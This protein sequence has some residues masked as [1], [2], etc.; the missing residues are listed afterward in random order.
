LG[1][2]AFFLKKKESIKPLIQSKV[3]LLAFRPLFFTRF[4][5]ESMVT[6]RKRS[7]LLERTLSMEGSKTP[8][9]TT[10]SHSLA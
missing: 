1:T 10:S 3:G 6:Q 8:L 5:L 7:V 4:T 2:P 9:V